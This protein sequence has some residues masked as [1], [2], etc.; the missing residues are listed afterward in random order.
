M[1]NSVQVFGLPRSG[2][3]LIE[4]IIR[5]YYNIDYYNIYNICKEI[6]YKHYYNKKIA[7]KHLYPFI[8]NNKIII[9]FREKYLE[10]KSSTLY[11]NNLKDKKN[12][13]EKYLSKIKKNK[14]N[15]NCLIIKYEELYSN[16]EK[17]LRKMDIF[18]NKKSI[19]YKL[20]EYK[21]DRSG[22]KKLTKIK[23]NN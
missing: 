7:I 14:D 22:G 17:I 9:I 11:Y 4:Y 19:S 2:T 10:N 21:C 12:I 23:M 15:K 18:L 3:N 20:P 5:Y 8:D 16:P 6:N 13:Y 1:K